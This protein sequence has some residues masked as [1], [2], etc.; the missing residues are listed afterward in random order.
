LGHHEQSA[1]R[2]I[3]PRVD[4]M[5]RIGNPERIACQRVIATV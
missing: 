5:A 2:D 4:E 3:I 1:A